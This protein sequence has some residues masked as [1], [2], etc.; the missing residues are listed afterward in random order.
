MNLPAALADGA[1]SGVESRRHANGTDYAVFSP[2]RTYR[3][4]LARRW[5]LG[6]LILWLM[7][8]PS[9]ADAMSDDPTCRRLRAFTR[10]FAP[11]AGG[12]HVVNLYALRATDPTELWRHPDPVGPAGDD[13]LHAAAGATA[14]DGLPVIVAW[15]MHGARNDRGARVAADLAAARVRMLCLGTTQNGQPRH[16]LYVRGDTPLQPYLSEGATHVSR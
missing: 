6:P 13:A 1:F 7:L 8:N 9:T 10:R 16:P 12:F 15:G 2:D 14:M 4:E 5:S 11:S 3:Y